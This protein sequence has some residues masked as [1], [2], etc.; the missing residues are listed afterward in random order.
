MHQTP[1]PPKTKIIV[2]GGKRI[3]MREVNIWLE[4]S[5]RIS[6]DSASSEKWKL[7]LQCPRRAQDTGPSSCR[8][9]GRGKNREQLKVCIQRIGPVGHTPPTLLLTGHLNSSVLRKWPGEAQEKTYSDVWRWTGG[10]WAGGG[11]ETMRNLACCS[12]TY[13]KDSWPPSSALHTLTIS[14]SASHS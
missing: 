14:L 11:E 4:D 1:L 2:K 13:P 8:N 6:S 3:E 10:R 7:Q 12:N 9:R 5:K